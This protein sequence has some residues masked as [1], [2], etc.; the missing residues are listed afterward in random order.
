MM[1]KGYGCCGAFSGMGYLVLLTRTIMTM[2]QKTQPIVIRTELGI[3]V[4]TMHAARNIASESTAP[5]MVMMKF[6]G[7]NILV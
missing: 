5:I 2:P 6:M 7:F 1:T 4:K 3:Q